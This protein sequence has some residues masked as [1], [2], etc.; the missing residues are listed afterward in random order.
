MNLAVEKFIWQ[1]SL[2]VKDRKE[3]VIQEAITTVQTTEN[4]SS[5]RVWGVGW[6]DRLREKQ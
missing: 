3:E 1:M 4:E 6:C 5:H 2:A